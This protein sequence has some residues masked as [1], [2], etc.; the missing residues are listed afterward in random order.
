MDGCKGETS[1]SK[2]ANEYLTKLR[3]KSSDESRIMVARQLYHFI[4]GDLRDY[5]AQ[6]V[7]EFISTFDA[8]LDQSAIYELISSSD[9]DEKKSG[10]LL[11][12]CLVESAGDESKRVPRFAKYLLKALTNSDEAGMKLA[13]RAI[14]YLIQTSKT[15]AVELVEKSLNQVCEWLEEPERH[16]ARRLAAV[17]LARQLALYTSTSFFLRAS[18]FFTNIF[19]VIRDPKVQVRVFA[20]KALRAAL[21]VTSQREA[22]QKSEWYRHCYEEAIACATCES[23]NREDR[24]HAMLLILNELLRIGNA[25]AEKA[26]IKSLGR[27]PIQN[28]RTVIGSNAI[29]WLTEEIYSATVDSRTA[30]MLIAEKFAKIYEVCSR[31]T[32]C[33]P[34]YCQTVLLEILPRL[35]SFQKTQDPNSEYYK[36][37]WVDPL[38][39]FSYA[40]SL[41]SKHPRALLTIGLLVLD[42]PTELRSKIGQLLSVIQLMLQAAVN[43]R[44]PVDESVFT[45]LT[46]VVRA[47]DTAVETEMRALLPLI[48]STGLSKGSVM[49]VT[50]EA[51]RCIP[52]LKTDVQDGMLNELCQLLMNRKLPSKLDPP[53]SPPVPSAPVQVSNVALTKLALAAL[54]KFDFQR[55]AL[56]MFIKYIA[57]GYVMC[58]N[59][60]VRLAGVECCAEMLS[61]FVRVFEV[62]DR[63]QRVDVL[64]LIQSVLRQLVSVA[65]VDPCKTSLKPDCV[66]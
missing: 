19:N 37:T 39:M 16:E 23:L 42:R 28:V 21:T 15:F 49:E 40:L 24:Q 14:A 57:H 51:M 6:Y 17:L 64:N 58:E 31:A 44:K 43:K 8:R 56:Q 22:K 11:I 34:L 26:R 12:V 60:E 27:Q 13:A 35:S 36:T 65:V 2:K 7:N 54:G 45:C 32:A 59:A 66:L 10:I 20:A 5:S 18:H 38:P 62:A 9:N 50:H 25:A 4:N 63:K 3:K 41:T 46:L 55:H 47:L 52:G 1:A 30:R 29:D 61:P 48:F 33:R 53:S